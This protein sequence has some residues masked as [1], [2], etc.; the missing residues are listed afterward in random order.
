MVAAA[1]TA[2]KFDGPVRLVSRVATD[3]PCWSIDRQAVL[4]WDAGF[5]GN[6][7]RIQNFVREKCIV[8]YGVVA[9]V[10]AGNVCAAAGI[11]S[12]V[13]NVHQEL[14][15]ANKPLGF[16]PLPSAV[17]LLIQEESASADPRLEQDRAT[18]VSQ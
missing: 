18:R 1:G 6:V 13:L 10:K 9:S 7:A 4:G 14:R 17:P 15:L 12:L 5:G 2:P 16:L 8:Q 11:G 3:W